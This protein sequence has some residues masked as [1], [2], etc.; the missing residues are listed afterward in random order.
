MKIRDN[1]LKVLYQEMAVGGGAISSDS[2]CVFQQAR[3]LAMQQVFG[4]VGP[5]GGACGL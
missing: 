2:Q 1:E 3:Q 5:S 4:K